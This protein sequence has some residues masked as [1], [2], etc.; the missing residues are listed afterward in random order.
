MPVKTETF[1]DRG[2]KKHIIFFNINSL[3]PTENTPFWA[4]RKKFI[5]LISWERTQKRGPHKLFPGDL[6]G[7]KGGP[8]RAIFGHKK[9]S[10]L[11]FPALKRTLSATAPYEFPQKIHMDQSLAHT[12]SWGN[13]YGP[14]VLK[15]LLKFPPRLAL[16]HGWLFPVICVA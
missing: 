15:V 12:F 14:M 3:A 10:L 13:S 16:V 9:L 7:S 8:K 1:R 6:G 11:F 2:P 4:P 5:C